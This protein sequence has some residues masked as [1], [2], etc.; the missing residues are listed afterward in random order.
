MLDHQ[1]YISIP[2]TAAMGP[3]FVGTV[4]LYSLAYD[5]ADVTDDDNLATALL[6]AQI[7]D[8]IELTVMVR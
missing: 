2:A 3:V 6:S 8:S 4:T 5:T 7:Y 1:D